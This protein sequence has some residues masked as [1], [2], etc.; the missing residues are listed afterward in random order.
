MKIYLLVSGG[1]YLILFFVCFM[2]IW[3]MIRLYEENATLRRRITNMR[4]QQSVER[5]Q[6]DDA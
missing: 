4:V 3:E 1:I 5:H 6:A 2:M